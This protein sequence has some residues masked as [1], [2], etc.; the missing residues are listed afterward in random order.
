MLQVKKMFLLADDKLSKEKSQNISK[1]KVSKNSWM[2]L[3]EDHN[4]TTI[5]EQV[6]SS[7]S[8]CW[9][10]CGVVS[11]LRRHWHSH[12]TR[13]TD[14]NVVA[15]KWRGL[16]RL[17]RIRHSIPLAARHQGVTTSSTDKAKHNTQTHAINAQLSY[18]PPSSS[19]LF[20]FSEHHPAIPVCQFHSS[21]LSLGT[22]CLQGRWLA[23]RARCR[24]GDCHSKPA[25]KEE[26]VRS[27][28]LVLLT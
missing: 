2:L 26:R 16:R 4:C 13:Q 3:I 7:D 8:G 21:P 17:E 25:G 24:C 9:F 10:L 11:P 22:N 1:V 5:T 14:L 20:L 27:F 19:S 28:P 18:N 15:E 6:N 23:E 12:K